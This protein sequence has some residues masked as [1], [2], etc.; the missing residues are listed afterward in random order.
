MK[1][2]L[3]QIRQGDVLLDP[4]DATPPADALVTTEVILARG[5][6]T[7]HAHRL[8]AAAGIIAWDNFVVVMGDKPGFLYHEDHDPTP[9]SVVVPRQTY[10]IIIQEE[11]GLDEMWRQIAD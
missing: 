3:G 10:Q 8:T 4:V 7:G 11:F 5:E 6:F 2:E 1:L 9:A